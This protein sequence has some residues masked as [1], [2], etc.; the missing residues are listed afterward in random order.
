MRDSKS[1]E[2]LSVDDLT[3]GKLGR[4]DVDLVVRS[5]VGP[6]PRKAREEVGPI[7]KSGFSEEQIAYVLRQVASGRWCVGSLA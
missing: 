4:V 5:V 2:V 1:A 6:Q 3:P 7:K